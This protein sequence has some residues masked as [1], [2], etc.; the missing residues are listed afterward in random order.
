MMLLNT[1]AGTAMAVPWRPLWRPMCMASNVKTEHPRAQLDQLHFEAETTRNKANNARLRFLRLSDA[2]E[3][4]KRQAAI[5]VRNGQE[6]DARE[7][8]FQRKKVMEAL[9]KSKSRIELLDELS[10]KLNEAISLK[11]SQ[12]IGNVALDLE[13]T[14]EEASSPVRI[15][16][17]TSEVTED[18]IE[19]KEFGSNN[20]KLSDGQELQV[21]AESRTSLPGDQ[22][23][24][25]IQGPLLGTSSNG[26]DI[27]SSL[28]GISSY[29]DFLEHLD[30][31]LNKIEAELFTI[32]RISTLVLDGEEGTK[33]VKVLQVLELLDCIR[34]IR[35]RIANIKLAELERS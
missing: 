9:E 18:L 27:M 21:S 8:L 25:E 7:L 5:N 32:S 20:L 10:T 16:S 28:K 13:V 22:E 29:D 14:I 24:E 19:S 3:N 26:D 12:L 2:A 1:G 15:V 31:Q 23:Q 33:N 6:S 30:Q 34:G 17:P 35:Q 11:E 4:L